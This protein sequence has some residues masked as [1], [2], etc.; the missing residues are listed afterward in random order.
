MIGPEELARI[1]VEAAQAAR[2]QAFERRENHALSQES[3]PSAADVLATGW[4][5]LDTV[6]KGWD[7]SDADSQAG[8][9]VWKSRRY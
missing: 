3:R 1:Q 4:D 2:E 9:P 5:E 8:K 6:G 7:I